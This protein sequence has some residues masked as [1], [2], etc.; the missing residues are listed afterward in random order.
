MTVKS[1]IKPRHK[2]S[3]D[4]HRD[5]TII[6]SDVKISVYESLKNVRLKSNLLAKKLSYDFRVTRNRV[7]S[8]RETETEN[9]ADEEGAEDH[10]FLPVH[11]P[12][13]PDEKVD[14]SADEHDAAK[15]MSPARE[16]HHKTESQN[17]IEKHSP[18]V[19]CLRV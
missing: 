11:F 15:Q 4:K 2:R 5:A 13:R 14:C 7:E 8:K 17:E 1:I 16:L 6:Q 18:N 10:F 12:C 3:H 9:G 19:S